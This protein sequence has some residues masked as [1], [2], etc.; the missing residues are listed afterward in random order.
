MWEL[1]RREAR[2]GLGRAEGRGA[3]G[4]L[5][6]HHARPRADARGRGVLRLL[7]R[8]ARTPDYMTGQSVMIDGGVLFA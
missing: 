5:P 6:A 4:V 1:H 8:L 3:R 2:R 7:P